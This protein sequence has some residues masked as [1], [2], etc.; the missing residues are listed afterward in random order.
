MLGYRRALEAD[1]GRWAAAGHVT[2][3]GREA[4]LAEVALRSRGLGVAPILAVLGATLLCFGVMLFVGANWQDMPRIARLGILLAGLWAAYGSAGLLTARG[5]PYFANAAILFAVGLF[6]AA[7]MLIGQMYNLGA[8]PAAG[9]LLW[10]SGAAAAGGLLRSNTAFVAAVLLAGTWTSLVTGDTQEPHWWFVPAWLALFALI[11][12]T[13]RWRPVLH[14][15]GIVGSL[16]IVMLG[17]VLRDGHAHELVVGIGLAILAAAASAGPAIDNAMATREGA[18]S[19][20]MACHGFAIAVVGLFALQFFDWTGTTYAQPWLAANGMPLA[21]LAAATLALVLGG[22]WL[23]VQRHFPALTWLAY[24]S[25]SVEI[26]ALYFKTLGTLLDTSLFFLSA[27]V[28]VCV[29]AAIAWRLH[30]R[31]SAPAG[32]A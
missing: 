8:D 19:R 17:Y 9:V 31:Q 1:L 28:L 5:Y 16:W 23:G 30:Q 6:G 24:I 10:L 20:P 12:L 18:L 15:A 14:L 32:A 7:I 2:P 11:W 21:L 26:V 27:G 25:F 4:I 3:A 13:T 22:L 29:L